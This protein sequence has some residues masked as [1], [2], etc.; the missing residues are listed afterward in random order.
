MRVVVNKKINN[1]N[2]YA[3]WDEIAMKQNMWTNLNHILTLSPVPSSDAKI[4][5]ISHIFS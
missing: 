1:L 5:D 4:R 3:E 2:N